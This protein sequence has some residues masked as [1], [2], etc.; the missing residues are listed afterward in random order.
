MS[1][2]TIWEVFNR[3]KNLIK[4]YKHWELLINKFHVKLGSCAAITK[5]HMAAFSEITEEE[6]A[7]YTQ[8]VRDI[9]GALK[10]CF[11]YDV[12]HH[13]ML[14]FFDKHTHF[15]II[16]RYQ[17]SR[18]FAG[19]EWVDDFDPNPLIQKI[20]PVSQPVLDQIKEKIKKNV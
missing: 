15:H 10:K 19:I 1:C 13:L 11:Q 18:K 8:V 7:E 6:L 2:C 9:E 16:P 20:N 12:I 4:E 17:E 3:E 5:R 14:M